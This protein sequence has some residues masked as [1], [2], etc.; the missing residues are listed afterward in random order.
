MSAASSAAR[1]V[2]TLVPAIE[3][4]TLRAVAAAVLAAASF[5]FALASLSAISASCMRTW[6]SSA[7]VFFASMACCSGVGSGWSGSRMPVSARMRFT[8][9]S[10]LATSISSTTRSR[11]TI[12]TSGALGAMA[13][14]SSR[15]F[16]VFASR[17]DALHS[18]SDIT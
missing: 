12:A 4:S 18:C 17:T 9:S 3:A 6:R 8:I 15:S 1:W 7:A 11:M 13:L 16:C 2:A 14:M 10:R 5:C